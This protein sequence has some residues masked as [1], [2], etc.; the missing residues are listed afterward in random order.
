M[1]T[2]TATSHTPLASATLPDRAAFVLAAQ[3]ACD[4]VENWSPKD[5]LRA[6]DKLEE[7]AHQ[8]RGRWEAAL[9]PCEF[10]QPFSLSTYA[11]KNPAMI[12][13]IDL[14]WKYAANDQS[15]VIVGKTGVGKTVLAKA[16]HAASNVRRGPFIEVNT[17]ILTDTLFDSQMFG[18]EKGAFTGADRKHDGYLTLAEGGTLFIDDIQNL[19]ID[20][21]VKLLQVLNDGKFRPLGSHQAKNFS[22][23]VI[24]GTQDNLFR[25]VE[26]K[27][28]G[29]DLMYRLEQGRISLPSMTQ[30]PEDLVDLINNQLKASSEDKQRAGVAISDGAWMKLLGHTWPGNLRELKNVMDKAVLLCDGMIRAN[31]I[32]FPT[33]ETPIEA[34]S[35]T[36]DSLI[37][38]ALFLG[39]PLHMTLAAMQDAHMA[40]VRADS[41]SDEEAARRLDIGVRTFYRRRDEA[42]RVG[43]Q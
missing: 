9:A 34:A 12:R 27:T 39:Y 24:V 8:L 21:G 29:E 36:Q 17:G 30:R 13:A 19:K 33:E 20:Q 2:A 4:A 5:G 25:L 41:R 18:H 3:Q 43:A 32:E 26:K 37:E 40:A 11:S 14:A 22:A 1:R 42:G 6:L 31:D 16:I 7:F 15:L 38:R 35:Y 23:R 28:F 10:E